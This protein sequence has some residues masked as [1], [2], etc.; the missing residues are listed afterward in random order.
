MYFAQRLV[1]V[2]RRQPVPEST[3]QTL[4]EAYGVIERNC[5]KSAYYAKLVLHE[6]FLNA[7]NSV[8]KRRQYAGNEYTGEVTIR[9]DVTHDKLHV[10]VEDNGTGV[11]DPSK[12]FNNGILEREPEYPG[13]ACGTFL[14]KQLVEEDLGGRI[15]YENKKPGGAHFFYEIPIRE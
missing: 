10:G 3:T 2:E 4:S 1:Y 7:V 12:L 11:D 15:G 6:L 14:S 9:I 5:S 8:K 13:G